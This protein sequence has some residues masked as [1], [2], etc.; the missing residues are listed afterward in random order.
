MGIF[1]TQI[2]N[3]FIF[4]FFRQL[5]VAGSRD[6]VNSDSIIRGNNMLKWEGHFVTWHTLLLASM[7]V[8]T[9]IFR[10]ALKYC[11][12]NQQ[13]SCWLWALINFPFPFM[14]QA[15]HFT[16]AALENPFTKVGFNVSHVLQQLAK[17]LICME[18]CSPSQILMAYYN[19][20]K[21]LNVWCA[22]W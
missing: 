14:V 18:Q 2:V 16:I 5:L 22:T 3:I 7:D 15:Y 21:I 6:T 8:S 12:S 9:Q 1:L 11:L 13:Y 4:W 17:S 20:S 19:D 10:W